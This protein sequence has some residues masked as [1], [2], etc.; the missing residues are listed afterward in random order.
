MRCTYL[1][2]TNMRL[3]FNYNFWRNKKEFSYVSNLMLILMVI[4]QLFYI[5]FELHCLDL[6]SQL[7][8]DPVY[9]ISLIAVFVPLFSLFCGFNPPILNF[10]NFDPPIIIF[11][12][13]LMIWYI[14]NGVVYNLVMRKYQ[15]R[16]NCKK[17]S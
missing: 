17:W 8:S 2:C 14:L 7:N 5:K 11:N 16:W 3:I 9:K 6:W 12:Y 4:F 10:D 1:D 13:K 15:H